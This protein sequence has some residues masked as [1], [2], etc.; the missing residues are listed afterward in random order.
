MDAYLPEIID[1]LKIY[2]ENLSSPKVFP[3][4]AQL[5]ACDE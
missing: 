5:K 4:I 3:E 1:D 2:R